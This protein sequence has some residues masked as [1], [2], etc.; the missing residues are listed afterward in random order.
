MDNMTAKPDYK[1]YGFIPQRQAGLLLMRLRHRAG[2]TTAEDLRKAAD[3]AERFGTGQI[4]VTLRQGIE[5]PG[6]KEEMFEQALQAIGDAGLLPA[7]C[8]LRVRPIVACPGNST[9][10]YGLIDTKSLAKTLDE[11]FVG[12]DL[13]AKCKFAV[14]GCANSCTKPQAH[15]IGMRGAVEPVTDP[16][17]CVT[18]GACVRR[19]PAQ[20]MTIENKVLTIDYD[21][22]L[23]CGV[24][25][26]LCPKQA[27][28]VGKSGCHILIGGKGGRYP[29][30]AELLAKF[31]PENEITAYVEAVLAIYQELANKG[32]RLNSVLAEV[33]M[34]TIRTRIAEKLST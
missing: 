18:C 27:L 16:E 14:S 23:S 19:C 28:K 32:Q 24:C 21:K 12:R 2:D 8:G 10:P 4:H 7:V 25:I 22:C 33:G 17:L 5:I 6:V 11:Q 1:R 29:K 20:A 15:D 9:C 31:I 26:R 34:T 3:L 30:S 13:P